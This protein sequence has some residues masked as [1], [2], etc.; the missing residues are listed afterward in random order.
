[1]KKIFISKEPAYYRNPQWSPNSKYIAF[2]DNRLN[3]WYAEIAT[4]KVTKIHTDRISDSN[5]DL[6]WS[7]DSNWIAFTPALA[8]RLHAVYLYSL[9][10]GKST[11]ITDGMSDS[12]SPAFDRDGQYLYFAASTDFGTSISGLD[13]SS[14]AFSTTRSIY[15]IVLNNE[16]PSPVAPESD[17]E[18]PVGI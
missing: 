7:P 17:E 1:M 6:A 9:E 18:K 2:H 8:N 14:D 5:A 12:R 4:G 3:F 15:A 13:M 10:S 11:Q 16:S